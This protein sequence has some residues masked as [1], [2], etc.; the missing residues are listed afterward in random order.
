MRRPFRAPIALASLA[1]GPI[2]VASTALGACICNC[3]GRW[4]SRSGWPRSFGSSW[5]R[6][7]SSFSAHPVRIPNIVGP[8]SCSGQASNSPPLALGPLD[9]HRG[10][11]RHRIAWAATGLAAGHRFGLISTSVAARRSA[12]IRLLGL[13][14]PFPAGRGTANRPAMTLMSYHRRRPRR[15]RSRLA[16][17]RGGR[18]GRLPRC[19]ARDTTAAH[20]TDSLAELVCSNSFRSDISESNAVGLIHAEMRPVSGR[21]HGDGRR[22]RG[23]PPGR[24]SRST[25]RLRRRGPERLGAHH[26]IELFESGSTP[27]PPRL[28]HR[29]HR[30]LTALKRRN[31]SGVTGSDALALRRHRPDRPQG[32]ID[33]DVA[34]MRARWDKGARI[35]SLPDDEGAVSR[36]PPGPA[37]REKTEYKDWN[38]FPISKAACRSR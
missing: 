22:S 12:G 23:C 28:D 15:V 5:C 33:M 6:F 37:R 29:R 10:A 20:H 4:T 9:R 27:S 25:A 34:W 19:A 31:Q 8:A 3:R 14:R 30:P 2:F 35:T 7:P 32:S 17:R 38:R 26:H 36:L 1:A 13:R 21:C 11:V 24:R 16:A 18:A